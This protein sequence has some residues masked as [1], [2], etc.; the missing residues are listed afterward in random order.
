MRSSPEGPVSPVKPPGQLLSPQEFDAVIRRAAELQAHAADGQGSEGMD[1][2]ELVRIGKELGLSTAHLQQAIA[3]VRGGGPPE[4]G[5]LYKL[6]GPAEIR[7]SRTVPG[8][9]EDLRENLERYL[10]EREYYTVLRRFH[11]RTIYEQASGVHA[12]VGR[13]MSQAFGGSRLLG[14]RQ[15]EVA[16]QP[17]EDGFS[18][19]T[20][21]TDL[22]AQRAGVAT[23]AVLGG[24]GGGAAVAT[25]LGIAVA[26]PAALLGLPIVAGMAFIMRATYNSSARKAH[27]KLE[28]LLDRIQ[29]SE[30][31]PPQRKRLPRF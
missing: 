21:G 16:V 5:V 7:A 25:A 22:S 14:F 2:A 20:L 13:S 6:F 29:H 3:E 17:L 27:L 1:P 31:P 24:G 8:N 19:V 30:L 23:G 4:A 9:A 18:Y 11:D 15:L 28:S 12:T 26:P 10:L